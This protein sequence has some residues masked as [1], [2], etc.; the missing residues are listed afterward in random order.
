MTF[1]SLAVRSNSIWLV[2]KKNKTL[3]PGAKFQKMRGICK[4]RNFKVFELQKKKK[5][6]KPEE[7]A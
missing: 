1:P 2:K 7:V 3:D 5:A 6:I 4:V